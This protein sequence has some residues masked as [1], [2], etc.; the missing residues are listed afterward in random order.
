M[1]NDLPAAPAP[2][3]RILFA[4]RKA[5]SLAFERKSFAID[6]YAFAA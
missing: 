3:P 6:R 1:E 4:M 5:E 2:S